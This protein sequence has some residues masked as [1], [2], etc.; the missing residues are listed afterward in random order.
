MTC[1]GFGHD[2]KEAAGYLVLFEG[3]AATGFFDASNQRFFIEWFDAACVYD[4]SFDSF[5][6]EFLCS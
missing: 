1:E 2:A 4:F 5:M 6:T 3:D